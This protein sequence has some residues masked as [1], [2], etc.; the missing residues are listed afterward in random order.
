MK[1][2]EK[3]AEKINEIN[4]ILNELLKL[5]PNCEQ[6]ALKIAE[7]DY[8]LEVQL[9]QDYEL[10]R[11]RILKE[12]NEITEH[13]IPLKTLKIEAILLHILKE[14]HER[15]NNAKETVCNMSSRMQ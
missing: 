5:T 12:L 14:F 3:M 11:S 4:K 2:K 6:L 7:K 9:S 13:N 8:W 15:K 1:V 10:I